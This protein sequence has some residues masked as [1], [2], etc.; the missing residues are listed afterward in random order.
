[1]ILASHHD[2]HPTGVADFF[3]KRLAVTC[4]LDRGRRLAESVVKR[5]TGG[6]QIRARRMRE[7]FFEFEQTHTL[8]IAGNH[9]PMIH[10]T[11]NGIWRRIKLIPFTIQIPDEQQDKQLKAKLLTELPG[12]LN[13]ALCGCLEWQNDGLGDA[14]VVRTATSQYRS[15]MDQIGEFLEDC[16]ELTESRQESATALY[17]AYKNWSERRGEKPANQ[18]IFGTDLEQRGHAKIR[19]RDGVKRCGIRLL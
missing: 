8:W 10:G 7:D 14:A 1:M 16:C 15:E 3:G 18:K 9:K 6:D 17:Q 4:E 12:I 5:L 13:W 19:R 2:H 11:E